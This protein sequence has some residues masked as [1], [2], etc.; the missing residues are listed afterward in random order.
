MTKENLLK[1]LAVGIKSFLGMAI[2]AGVAYLY[3][4]PLLFPSLGASAVLLYA[5]E[6]SPMAKPRNVIG[7]HLVSAFIGVNINHLIGNQWWA[8]AIGI[9]LAI[10]AMM[11]TNTLHPPGGAT[12]FVAIYTTQNLSFVFTPV[13]VG[14]VM[15]TVLSHVSKKVIRKETRSEA[16]NFQLPN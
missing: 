5:V 2:I 11:L 10:M 3:N 4:L 9:S 13:L 1:T 8:L 12:A 15:L 16:D 7:G 14:A 6:N